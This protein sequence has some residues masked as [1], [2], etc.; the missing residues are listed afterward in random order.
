ML[1]WAAKQG[2]DLSESSARS[3]AKLIWKHVR[4]EVKNS[5]Q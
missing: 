1:D 5:S 4:D 2:F 3:K